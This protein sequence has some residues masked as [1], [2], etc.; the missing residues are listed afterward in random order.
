MARKNIYIWVAV[1]ILILAAY[2][3]YFKNPKLNNPISNGETASTTTSQST[4]ST[5][6][7]TKTGTKSVP[8]TI[9][10]LLEQSKNASSINYPNLDFIDTRTSFNLNN[11]NGVKVTIERIVFGRGEVVNSNGCSSIL[12]PDFTAYFYPN[13]SICIN[14]SDVDGAPHAI[15]SLHL[16]IDNSSQYGF[17]GID[18]FK[19]HYL[20]ADPSG[21]AKDKFAYPLLGLSNYNLKPYTSKEV[22]LSYIVPQDQLSYDFLTNYT[23][24]MFGLPPGE[25]VYKYS[26][27]GLF[28]NFSDKSISIVK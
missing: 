23:G 15:V 28:I 5:K 4:P 10:A 24:P 11:Y 2:Y 27:Q 19:L 9:G 12:S 14:Q 25:T 22:V 8:K 7:S 13:G 16:L 18:L 17:G 20:R 21:A 26:D 1:I 3:L 6:T